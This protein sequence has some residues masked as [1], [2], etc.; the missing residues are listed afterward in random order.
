V[1]VVNRRINEKSISRNALIDASKLLDEFGQILGIS[2]SFAKSKHPENSDDKI[3]KLIE[4]LIDVRQKL[5]EKKDWAL[6]D[7]IRNRLSELGII[8]E[9][10]KTGNGK[11]TI[12]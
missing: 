3:G 8:L 11:Y 2:F 7:E 5:R 4:L 9:D 12:K 1:R 6:A 10:A